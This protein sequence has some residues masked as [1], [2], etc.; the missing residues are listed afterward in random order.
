M[1]QQDGSSDVMTWEQALAY[2]EGL[3]LG[4]YTDWRLP[5]IKELRSLVDYS[6]YNPAI[7]TTYLSG[8]GFVLFIGR[9]LPTRTIRTTRG[10][11]TSTTAT[12]TATIRTTSYYVRAV[13]GGQSG[14]LDHS[15]LSVSP[16]NQDVA[17]RCRHNH[18]QRFQHRNRNNHAVDRRGDIRRQ[19]AADHFRSQRNGDRNRNNH[20]RI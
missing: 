3:N 4:G 6:R 16:S 8:Y 14:S 11:W 7:N 19:L 10:A 18:I 5:T 17:E 20:L 15:V 13:R 1:W 9:L 2:C 12:T